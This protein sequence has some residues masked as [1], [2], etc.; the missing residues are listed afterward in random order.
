MGRVSDTNSR[1]LSPSD[2][3]VM[4]TAMHVATVICSSCETVFEAVGDPADL[5]AL[6]CRMCHGVLGEFYGG[7]DFAAPEWEPQPGRP[8]V[9]VVWQPLR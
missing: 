6:N 1:S 5:Q 9:T 8:V 3:E 2:P 4:I 7:S